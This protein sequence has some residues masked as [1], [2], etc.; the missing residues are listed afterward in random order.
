MKDALC[1]GQ[2]PSSLSNN[3]FEEHCRKSVVR[4]QSWEDLPHDE[5]FGLS[6]T[7]VMFI[8]Y[9]IRQILPFICSNISITSDL[10]LSLGQ[11]F[12]SQLWFGQTGRDGCNWASNLF[13]LQQLRQWTERSTFL[14]SVP[15][16]EGAPHSPRCSH[17]CGF[18][19]TPLHWL[20]GGQGNCG[21][22]IRRMSRLRLKT[23]KALAKVIWLS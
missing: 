12:S 2:Q 23:W 9:F 7:N 18:I 5:I 15:P 13:V 17:R 11:L 21:I 14:A 10:G 4:P 19:A 1:V 20:W 6:L 3:M 22:P 16:T 8:S